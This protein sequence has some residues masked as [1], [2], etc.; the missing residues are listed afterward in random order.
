MSIVA[1]YGPKASCK[2]TL[3]S[4]YP[5]KTFWLDLEFGAVRAWDFEYEMYT[6][7]DTLY[8]KPNVL[9]Q[10][11]V[12]VSTITRSKRERMIG[13][14]ELWD[15]ITDR[16]IE[17]LQDDQYTNIAVDTAKE[18][19]RANID[20]HLQE[21]Q[22]TQLDT[23]LLKVKALPGNGAAPENELIAI[24]ESTVQW[25]ETL[26]P[27]EYAFPN[28]RMNNFIDLA[29]G[30]N[31]NL[32]LLNHQRDVYGSMIIDGKVTSAPTGE[33]ELDGYKNT[34]DR[35]DWSFATES[36]APDPR[37]KLEDQKFFKLIIKKSPIGKDLEGIELKG[38][39]Y[40]MLTGLV[41][42]FGRQMIE[43]IPSNG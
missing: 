13:R 17:A 23:A 18:V 22:D 39:T 8:T 7:P 4:T 12:V 42:K 10:P 43:V 5:G 34:E 36:I 35:V 19:W 21:K 9:W 40:N 15:S 37:V 14:R 16:Y 25:R 2:S 11:E 32:I 6:V 20:G 3:A 26:Q 31:K 28:S 1:I 38:A 24:A 41:T 33:K 30:M 29:R 27:I